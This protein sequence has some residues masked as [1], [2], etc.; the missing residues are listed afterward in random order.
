MVGMQKIN[1]IKKLKLKNRGN[2]QEFL[3]TELTPFDHVESKENGTL[4]QHRPDMINIQPSPA[5]IRK[6]E[7]GGEPSTLMDLV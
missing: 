5:P 2:D 1:K 3:D 7:T 6:Q 4:F